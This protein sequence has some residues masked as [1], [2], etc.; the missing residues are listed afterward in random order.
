VV[1]K[2]VRRSVLPLA[3]EQLFGRL[4]IKHS[5]NQKDGREHGHW[6]EFLQ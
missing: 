1:L 6:I 5:I 2:G 4:M 3:L